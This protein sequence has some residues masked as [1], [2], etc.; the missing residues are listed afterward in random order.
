MPELALLPD[1]EP[2]PMVDVLPVAAL[3]AVRALSTA[4]GPVRTTV[5]VS[6]RGTAWRFASA[7]FCGETPTAAG[8]EAL[9][10]GAVVVVCANA[11]TDA[12]VMATPAIKNLRGLNIV[13]EI[14]IEKS[15]L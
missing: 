5:A 14:I 4:S 6:L 3:A 10:I 9:P 7:A 15:L 2:V 11:A 1:A 13:V 12:P 8:V